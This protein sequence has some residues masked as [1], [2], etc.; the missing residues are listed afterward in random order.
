[1]CTRKNRLKITEDGKVELL[2]RQEKMMYELKELFISSGR[3]DME[4]YL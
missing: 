4:E 3:V 2:S 1:M